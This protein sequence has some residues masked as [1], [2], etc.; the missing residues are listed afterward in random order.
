MMNELGDALD[1]LNYSYA[2]V[3][4]NLTRAELPTPG[5]AALQRLVVDMH[6]R[7][8]E[9]ETEQT[10]LVDVLRSI[11]MNGDVDDQTEHAIAYALERHCAT[12]AE[13]DAYII[14]EDG[15]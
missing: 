14:H 13:M 5:N 1:N 7:I 10:R 4:D 9:L 6:E 12:V 8:A 3:N 11:W 2:A 15:T